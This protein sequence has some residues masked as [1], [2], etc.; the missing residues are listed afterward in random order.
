MG[1]RASSG[2]RKG[3]RHLPR[4]GS[5]FAIGQGAVYKRRRGLGREEH[6]ALI[7]KHLREHGIQEG[8]ALVEFPQ[9]LPSRSRHQLNQM[10]SELREE[11]LV[12]LEG[13]RPRA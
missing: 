3:T 8:V 1:V 5:C 10:L 11:G 2:R 12:R 6:K 4:R 7:L 9:L 13:Q